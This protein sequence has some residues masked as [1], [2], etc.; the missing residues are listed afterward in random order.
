MRD[1]ELH[2]DDPRLDHTAGHRAVRGVLAAVVLSMPAWLL[3]IELA[4]RVAG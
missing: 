2:P 3:V 4:R 1:H